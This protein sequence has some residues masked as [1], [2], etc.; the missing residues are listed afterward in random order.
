MENYFKSAFELADRLAYESVDKSD[1]KSTDESAYKSADKLADKR[2]K[3]IM[4]NFNTFITLNVD[5]SDEACTKTKNQQ[6]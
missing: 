6:L 5:K 4:Y 1:Y 3:W 2:S